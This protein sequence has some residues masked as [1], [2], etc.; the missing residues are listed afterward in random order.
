MKEVPGIVIVSI[1][2]IFWAYQ[3]YFVWCKPKKYI[4]DLHQRKMK[5]IKRAPFFPDWFINYIFYFEIPGVSIWFARLMTLLAVLVCLL[6]LYV[7]FFG[8]L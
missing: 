6:G 4:A 2:L 3:V 8:P 5:F 7:L 1:C